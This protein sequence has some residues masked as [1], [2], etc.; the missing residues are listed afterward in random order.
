[1]VELLFGLLIFV[2]VVCFAGIVSGCAL[3]VI[4]GLVLGN[5]VAVWAEILPVEALL[6]ISFVGTLLFAVGVCAEA[7]VVPVLIAVLALGIV[8]TFVAAFGLAAGIFLVDGFC[9]LA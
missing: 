7:G 2:E 8:F 6:I 9:W 3:V 5:D 4:F 1:M